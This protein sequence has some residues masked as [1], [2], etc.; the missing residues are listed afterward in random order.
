MPRSPLLRSILQASAPNATTDRRSFL[1]QTAGA[2]AFLGAA[3]IFPRFLYASAIQPR[4]AIIGA[5]IAGLNA[6]HYLSKS[7]INATIYEAAGRTGGRIFS[8]QNGVAA[9]CTCEIG[10]E[11]IDSSHEEMLR[12]AKEFHLTLKDARKDDLFNTAKNVFSIGGTQY[13]FKDVVQ[14]FNDHRERINR[15]A[16]T[17]NIDSRARE[18]GRL[19]H[20][21]LSGYFDE[22][23]LSGWFRK[24]LEAAYISEFGMPVE[25]QSSLNFITQIGGQQDNEF[26]MYGG[27]DE[28]LCIEGGNSRIIEKLEE[29]LRPQI[30]LGYGLA[31]VRSQGKGFVL[32]FANGKQVTA[33]Y[34]I[35][36]IPFTMLRHVEMR[37]DNMPPQKLKAIRELG[38]GNNSKLIMGF[39][40]RVW[41]E[42]HD[43]YGYLVHQ[44]IQNGWD[45]SMM[46]NGNKG[47][48]SYTVYVGGEDAVRMAHAKDRTR[49]VNEY[50][51]QLDAVFPGAQA[52]Y[53]G[54]AIIAD[55][56]VQP[57]IQASYASYKTGQWSTIRGWEQQSIGQLLFAGEHCSTDFQG[58]MN[59]G[60]E[61][62]KEAANTLLG[63]ISARTSQPKKG[64]H[65]H[66]RLRSAAKSGG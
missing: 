17:P 23:Q 27:S 18:M 8:K 54:R 36:T 34:V 10:A 16:L 38:Y 47:N 63:L 37:I 48:G 15:D 12:L 51:P 22:L 40:E 2:A 25:I 52:S 49:M 30:R 24:L 43:S 44:A 26:D 32:S 5:G 29:R 33:D 45:S 61:T 65:D 46:Q 13:S 53:N 21:P 14:A 60:A 42:Q 62:G 19:D 55:W 11:F 59:G 6:A 64:V 1:R 28:A 4:V 58:F 66:P 31:A 9:N 3:S 39:N 7:G 50:L 56:P 35:M 20:L 41:R 57:F